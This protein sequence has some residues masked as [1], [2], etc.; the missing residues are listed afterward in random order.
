MADEEIKTPWGSIRG[1]DIFPWVL[2][3]VLLWGVAW[4]INALIVDVRSSLSTHAATASEQHN[5]GSYILSVC[6]NPE[7][8]AECKRLNTQMPDSL[9]QK[10]RSTN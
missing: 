7:R 9:R 10:Q 2:I 4:M 3:V 1:K 6:L 5:E 8:V